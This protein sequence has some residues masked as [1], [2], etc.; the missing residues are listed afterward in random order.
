MLKKILLFLLAALIVLQFIRPEK[1]NGS[2]DTETDITH[3][4]TVPANVLGILRTSCYDCHSDHTTY[5]WYAQINPVGNWL[6]HHVSEGKRELN[7]SIAKTYSRKK[8]N[9]KLDEI[10]EQVE[11][12][13]MPLSSYTLVHKH[14]RLDATQVAVLMEWVKNAKAELGTVQ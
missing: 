10:R 14:A 3:A 7:F 1:N 12:Q 9:H 11:E 4:V 6:A 8:L 2:A 13:E 5:P